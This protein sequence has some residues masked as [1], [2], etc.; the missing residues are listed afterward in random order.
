MRLFIRK[1]VIK[2][3]NSHLK[4]RVKD[5][6]MDET[7]YP[8]DGKRLDLSGFT[9]TCDRNVYHDLGRDECILV[10]FDWDTRKRIPKEYVE[11]VEDVLEEFP[12]H[13]YLEKDDLEVID[14]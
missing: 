5:G 9:G 12:F 8:P 11:Y 4:V 6:I 13:Y 1:E 14:T 10:E 2:K 7:P 3:D